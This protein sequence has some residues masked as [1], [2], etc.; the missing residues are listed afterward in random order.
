MA[1]QWLEWEARQSG[2]YVQHHGNNK[3]KKIGNYLL[4][5]FAKRPIPYSRLMDVYFAINAVS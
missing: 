1:I 5:V 4:M 3:E 2:F